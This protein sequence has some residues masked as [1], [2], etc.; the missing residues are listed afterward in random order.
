VT[1][2]GSRA[3]MVSTTSNWVENITSCKASSTMC[4]MSSSSVATALGVNRS[5]I[6][7]RCSVWPGS[8]LLIID[9]SVGTWTDR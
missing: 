2:A 8:S 5:A 3:A 4:R 9:V 6:T 1:I 7:R